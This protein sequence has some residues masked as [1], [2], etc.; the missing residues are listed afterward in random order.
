M[1]GPAVA[2]AG[3]AAGAAS[4]DTGRAVAFDQGEMVI[5]LRADL[6]DDPPTRLRVLAVRATAGALIV[7]C[8]VEPRD[9]SAPGAA[10]QGIV[11]PERPLPVRVVIR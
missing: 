3:A 2:P 7:E 1:S 9:R 8:R 10:A 11:V 6:E 5:V 4:K